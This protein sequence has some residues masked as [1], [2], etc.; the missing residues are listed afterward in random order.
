[1]YL[2]A[3]VG[4]LAAGSGVMSSCMSAPRA[5]PRSTRPPELSLDDTDPEH[6]RVRLLW[7]Q[8]FYEGGQWDGPSRLLTLCETTTGMEET[9]RTLDFSAYTDCREGL[10]LDARVPL[11]GEYWSPPEVFSE[12]RDDFALLTIE[13]GGSATNRSYALIW[14]GGWVDPQPARAIPIECPL[15]ALGHLVG[16]DQYS[17]PGRVWIGLRQHAQPPLRFS[18]SIW[19]AGESNNFPTGGSVSGTMRVDR[20]SDGRPERLVVDRWEFVRE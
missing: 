17:A 6:G 13:S 20:G 15:A 16:P 8:R 11:G 10:R 9:G 5:E 19:N 4:I 1:M 12:G 14:L 7:A 2:I 18:F 3:I